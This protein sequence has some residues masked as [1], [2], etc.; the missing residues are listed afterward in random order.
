[1][2]QKSN[3]VAQEVQRPDV[4]HVVVANYV[5]NSPILRKNELPC[6]LKIEGLKVFLRLRQVIEK[7]SC[8]RIEAKNQKRDSTILFGSVLVL[9]ISLEFFQS[10]AAAAGNK[11]SSRP[12]HRFEIKF[13]DLGG[14]FFTN[15]PTTNCL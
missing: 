15:K 9:D 14:K 6:D 5:N 13:I 3:L 2:L 1:M 4:Q 11:I 12:K 10:Y 7:N 8:G